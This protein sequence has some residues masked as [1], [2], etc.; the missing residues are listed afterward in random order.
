MSSISIV[1]PE[2]IKNMEDEL[3]KEKIIKFK[4]EMLVDEQRYICD[5]CFNH[6]DYENCNGC[7]SK[8]TRKIVIS[9]L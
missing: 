5:E 4:A 2:Y 9:R 8:I 1:L 3:I 7:E 6:G